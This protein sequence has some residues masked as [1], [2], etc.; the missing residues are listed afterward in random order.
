MRSSTF[1]RKISPRQRRQGR[2]SHDRLDPDGSG[3]MT[4][5]PPPTHARLHE[6]AQPHHAP[7]HAMR[8]IVRLS[9]GLA[10]AIVTIA[11]A[12]VSVL[13]QEETTETDADESGITRLT[14]NTAWGVPSSW[15]TAPARSEN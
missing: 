13:A 9:A 11:F 4:T 10:L 3:K 2:K 6:P 15:A 5:K 1:W 14:D 12:S 8:K 7:W